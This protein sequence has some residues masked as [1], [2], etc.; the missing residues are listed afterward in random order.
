MKRFLIVIIVSTLQL[1]TAVSQTNL[2]KIVLS[3]YVDHNFLNLNGSGVIY[4]MNPKG[5]IYSKYNVYVGEG[6]QN[7]DGYRLGVLAT[8][9]WLNRNFYYRVNYFYNTGF[10]TLENL[11]PEEEAVN[12]PAWTGFLLAYKYRR[13]ESA[14]KVDLFNVRRLSFGAGLLVFYQIKDPEARIPESDAPPLKQYN[15]ISNL[16]DSYL[17]FASAAEINVKYRFGPLLLGCSFEKSITPI[18]KQ[19]NFNGVTSNLEQNFTSW[20]ISVSYDIMKFPKQNK[21]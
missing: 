17:M 11:H 12:G 21:K 4:N 5:E 19:V 13:I 18:A 8:H 15:I 3:P 7:M 10:S 16:A 20:A 6:N 9:R 2:P 14:F 1:G